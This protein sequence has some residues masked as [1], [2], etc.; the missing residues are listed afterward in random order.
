MMIA[1][2]D[3]LVAKTSIDIIKSTSFMCVCIDNYKPDK[4]AVITDCLDLIEPKAPAL[5]IYM[6][7][8]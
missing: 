3:A 6:S 8:I 2:A 7:Q 4:L 1:E 5:D